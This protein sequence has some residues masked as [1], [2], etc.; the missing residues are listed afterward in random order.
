[1]KDLFCLDFNISL[2]IPKEIDQIGLLTLNNPNSFCCV[3]IQ[4]F[5]F[6]HE[7]QFF[8]TTKILL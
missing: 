2:N 6:F 1:M 5:D 7:T 4:L 3:E 8:V